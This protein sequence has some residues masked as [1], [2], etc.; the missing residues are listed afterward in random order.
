LA[1]I[2]VPVH[3][4]EDHHMINLTGRTALVTG[5]SRGIGRATALLLAEAGARVIIADRS[6]CH[7]GVDTA[8]WSEIVR[9][10]GEAESHYLDV[11]DSAAVDALISDI[12]ERYGL[13][14]LVN[15]AGVLTS[16]AVGE[17]DDD[18]WSR[19]FRVNVDGTFYC[20][21]AGVRAMLEAGAGRHGKPHGKIVNVTSI[22]GLRGNPGFAAYCA[23][24]AAVVNLTRQAAIDYS[25]K[26]ININS[27]APGFVETDMTAVYD[28]PT[29]A[30]LEGQTPNGQWA[31]PRQIADA[32]LFLSSDLSDHIV[33]DILAVDGGWLVGTPVVA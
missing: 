3:T 4:K 21:R 14:I 11:T 25:P 29:R 23:S 19:Q 6:D 16:G 31:D 28:A 27:V 17:T 15:N 32:V 30:A 2:L 10:G 13:D 26:G 18:T 12:A 22:S 7:A 20:M 24:K 9:R 33:G 1:S 5:G 8:T